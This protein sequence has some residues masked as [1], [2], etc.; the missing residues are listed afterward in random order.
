MTAKMQGRAELQLKLA[1]MRKAAREVAPQAVVKQ[2]ERLAAVQRTL[3]P[4]DDGDLIKSI[5]VTKPGEA[6][7]AYSQPGGTRVAGETEAL[8]TAGNSKVRYA[9]LVEYDTAPH[10]NEGRFAGS[11]HPGTT[12]QPFFYPAYRLLRRSIKTQISRTLN[13]AIRGVAKGGRG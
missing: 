8:V 4:E 6:T 13:K 3:A 5:V 1:R 2:A 11:Q 7:P 10:I 12:A 9:H